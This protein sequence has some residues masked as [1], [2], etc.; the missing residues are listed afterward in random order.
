MCRVLGVLLLM[1]M[2]IPRPSFALQ[3][4]WGSGATTLSFTEATRCTLVVQSDSSE[5]RLPSEWRLLWVADGSTDISPVPIDAQFACEENLAQVSAVDGPSTPADSA[6]HLRTI[7]FCSDEGPIAT[8]AEYLLD[9]PA[10]SRGRFKAVALDPDD[11]TLVV[12]SNEATFN[13]GAWGEYPAAVLHAFSVHRSLQLQVTAIGFGLNAANTMSIMAPDSSWS[14]P[15]SVTSRTDGSV[16]GVASVAALLPECQVTVGSPMGAVSGATLAADNEPASESPQSC[17]ARFFEELLSP[18]PTGQL[19]VIQ[20]KDFAFTRG[21]V[22]ES[23]SRFALHLFYIRHNYWYDDTTGIGPFPDLNE[24]SIGHIYTTNFNSWYGPCRQDPDCPMTPCGGLSRADTCALKVRSGKFDE[25]H[26]WAPTIVQRGPTFWMFY[27]GVRVEQP[28]LGVFRRNQR[29]GRATSTDLITWEPADDVVLTAPDIP[30]ASKNPGNFDGQQL[31]DPFVMEDPINLGQWLMYFVAV[32]SCDVS[33]DPDCTP[34]M[35]V[36]AARSS[37]LITWQAFQDPF[38]STERPTFQGD[39]RVVESPHIFRR[40]GQWWMPYTVNNDQI[41]FETTPSADPADTVA[42]N[43][44]DP[45][46]LLDAAEDQPG[47]LLDWHASEFLRI[48]STQYLAAWNDQ[49]ASVDIRDVLPP[50][51]ATVDSFLLYCPTIAA[52]GD[53]AGLGSEVRMAVSRLR[54]G[55]P[56]VGLRLELPSRMAVR[57][58]VY[59]IAG[60]RRATLV[61]RELPAGATEVTWDGRDRSGARVA[62]GMYFVRLTFGGGSRRSKIVMLR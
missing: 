60:R 14:L 11:S 15:L 34:K 48:N 9:L 22:D 1:A 26:V 35:A 3:L 57:L 19:Y 2:L 45:V 30:W 50:A 23:T 18:P 10:E 37:D 52:V 7:Q 59:D 21:F 31:R 43:W 51:N 24:K 42:T 25:F 5:Q 54:W 44:T 55:A 61:D 53:G 41:F 13:G 20:P 16:T 4:H 28:Q 47:E 62:S 27:T 49:L 56:E 17:G 58:A 8:I 36:G 32:D 29:I 39:T 6:A 38:S 12:E 40:N 46:L 33:I